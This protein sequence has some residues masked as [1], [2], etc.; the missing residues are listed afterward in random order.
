MQDIVEE[1]YNNLK[2]EQDNPITLEFID[3]KTLAIS[4]SKGTKLIKAE[5]K[6][7]YRNNPK[8]DISF[9]KD[10]VI[11]KFSTYMT[12]RGYEVLLIFS[13]PVTYK[14]KKKEKVLLN[15]LELSLLENRYNIK[16]YPNL[17]AAP[18]KPL[19]PLHE[20]INSNLF[21]YL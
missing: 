17:Y 2:A 20:M 18:N 13:N 12:L 19:K 7:T 14:D 8:G 9:D 21:Y 5:I 10:L 4:M 1:F 6:N 3:L 15:N 16:E 11:V